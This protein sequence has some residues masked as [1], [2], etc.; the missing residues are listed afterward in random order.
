MAYNVKN[1]AAADG[2][3]SSEAMEGVRYKWLLNGLLAYIVFEYLRFGNWI[4]GIEA[5]RLQKVLAVIVLFFF[6]LSYREKVR[7]PWYLIAFMAVIVLS[8]LAN[9][10]DLSR[11]KALDFLF[12]ILKL[13][14]AYYLI[15]NLLIT[16]E[17][18][19]RF[20]FVYLF[21]NLVLAFFGFRYGGSE[22]ALSSGLFVGGFVSDSN[23]LALA[24]NVVI[25]FFWYLFAY[26]KKMLVKLAF[27]AAFLLCFIASTFTFSRGG[28]IGLAAIMLFTVLLS[29]N[30]L[31]NILFVGAL[32]AIA[33]QFIPSSYWE[34]MQTINKYETEGERSSSNIRLQLWKIGIVMAEENPVL[35]VGPLNSGFQILK[36]GPRVVNDTNEL[37]FLSGRIAHN[38]FISVASELGFTG[39]IIFIAFIV[40][41]YWNARASQKALKRKSTGNDCLMQALPSALKVSLIGYC[42]TTFF[43]TTYHYP[44][45][46]ILCALSFATKQI[47]L[48]QSG[49]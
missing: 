18:M 49:A 24:L 21:C 25:P 40:N 9:L 23:D 2:V 32:L 13:T 29:K 15:T 31:K 41:A 46:Y 47:A 45:I 22:G 34:R 42:V 35:G 4:P 14:A 5:L 12:L 37:Y 30:R 27:G 28:F 8:T 36:Y 16:R 17:N 43:L 48:N 6:I 33:S 1:L 26:E 3:S 44:H 20:I 7:H 11:A 38:T 10:G 19:K 39:L